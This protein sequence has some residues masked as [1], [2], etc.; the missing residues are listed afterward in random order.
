MYIRK[1]IRSYNGRTYTNYLLVESVHT[2]LD[3]IR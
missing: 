1:S 2:Q 3:P